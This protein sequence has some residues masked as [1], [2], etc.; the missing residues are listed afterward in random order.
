MINVDDEGVW[1]AP[2][3][4]CGTDGLH[5]T[6]PQVLAEND[7]EEVL[8]PH[9]AALAEVSHPRLG[10]LQSCRFSGGWSGLA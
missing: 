8:A 7:A 4:P 5:R 3:R 9:A 2:S 6:A 10:R 1:T